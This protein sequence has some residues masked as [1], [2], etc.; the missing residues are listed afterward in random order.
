MC[1]LVGVEQMTLLFSTWLMSG[2]AAVAVAAAALPAAFS[3][4]THIGSLL[5]HPCHA[6]LYI[7]YI[8]V[9]WHI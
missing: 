1:L 8:L 4:I 6:T 5:H 9:F 3:V 2:T 7:H